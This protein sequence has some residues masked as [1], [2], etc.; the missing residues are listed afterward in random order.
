[1]ERRYE[2]TMRK[3]LT[4]LAAVSFVVWVANSLA[5]ERSWELIRRVAFQLL[6]N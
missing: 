6:F 5:F 1:M 3:A 4:A 2:P